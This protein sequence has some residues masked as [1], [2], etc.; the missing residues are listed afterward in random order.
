MTSTKRYNEYRESKIK[1]EV[2]QLWRS[3]ANFEAWRVS[4]RSYLQKNGAHHLVA[5]K[6]NVEGQP[7]ANTTRPRHSVIR[8]FEQGRRR[9]TPQT[10]VTP[11]TPQE[12]QQQQLEQLL[13]PQQPEEAKAPDPDEVELMFLDGR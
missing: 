4:L 10:P 13:Q 1:I 5:A 2:T 7:V 12:Q 9:I 6:R 8:E 3:L 11:Q